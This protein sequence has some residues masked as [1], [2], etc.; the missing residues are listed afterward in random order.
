VSNQYQVLVTSIC[1]RSKYVPIKINEPG[2][3]PGLSW[4]TPFKTT[5]KSQYI[6]Q[7]KSQA[8][9]HRYITAGGADLFYPPPFCGQDNKILG[10]SCPV[11]ASS[12]V[13]IKNK[14]Q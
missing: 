13:W 10:G 3:I 9:H 7:R 11:I 12:V 14:K 6:E 4:R 1:R 2:E 5:A 8:I